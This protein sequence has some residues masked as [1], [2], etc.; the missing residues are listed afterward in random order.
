[1]TRLL[2]LT[3]ALPLTLLAAPL[4]AAEVT[5][6]SNGPVVELT[7]MEEVKARPDIVEIGAGVSTEARTAVAA[8]QSNAQ[9]MSAVIARIKALGID[10]DD[11]QTS[12]IRLNPQYDYNQN[13]RKQV[14]RG[15]EVV[16]QVSVTLRE[17]D[18]TGP[19][20]DALV[21]SG[22]TNLSGPGFR[23]EDET[24]AKDAARRAAM[25]TALQRARDYAG[26]AGYSN[27]R[28]L[29][30]NETVRNEMR[31]MGRVTMDAMTEEAASTPVQPGMVSTGVS[32]TITYEMTR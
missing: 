15:Y 12:G 30:V 13:T 22:A 25:E 19:V 31:P 24:A 6:E 10:E 14:F 1:M 7:V 5:L 21:A 2:S 27:V 18:R 9:Q 16:N 23:I 17:V 3:A 28:L 29:S 11:I 26:M 4:S 8:M 32:V 20:L